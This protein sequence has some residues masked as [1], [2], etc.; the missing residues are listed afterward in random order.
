MAPAAV[1]WRID[2]A[3]TFIATGPPSVAN[4]ASASVLS[5]CEQS[6]NDGHA[7]RAEE[8]LRLVLREPPPPAA[9]RDRQPPQPRGVTGK[10][11]PTRR[12]TATP[13]RSP[14]IA[15]TPASMNF[16]ADSSSS[17]SGS[18]DATMTGTSLT[19]APARMPSSTASQ[20]SAEWPAIPGG[21][22]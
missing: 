13:V 12:A 9:R 3:D 15:G 2:G 8:R 4:A 6:A 20:L 5:R 1:L 22:S 7:A 14:A 21:R 19:A 10:A 16:H 17:S 11:P 18:V